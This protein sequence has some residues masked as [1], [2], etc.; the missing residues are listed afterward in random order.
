MAKPVPTPLTIGFELEITLIPKSPTQIPGFLE[1][2]RDTSGSDARRIKRHNSVLIH[3]F[4]EDALNPIRPRSTDPPY[5]HWT[6]STDSSIRPTQDF[7]AVEIQSPKCTTVDP[8]A[9]PK[10]VSQVFDVLRQSFMLRSEVSCGIHVHT[11][12][13]TTSWRL[14]DLRSIARAVVMFSGMFTAL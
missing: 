8:D 3:A 10:L 6:V 14:S 12:L 4:I 7:Y 13:A 1:A 11:S 5:L 9:W 2:D